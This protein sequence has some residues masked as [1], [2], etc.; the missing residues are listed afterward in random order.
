MNK[1]IKEI[2]ED[3][4]EPLTND[5]DAN[6]ELLDIKKEKYKSH[7]RYNNLLDKILIKEKNY[8]DKKNKDAYEEMYDSKFTFKPNE[9]LVTIK[10]K[11]KCLPKD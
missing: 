1:E 8:L 11:T 7:P 3:V 6:L 9:N 5:Y 10:L 2:I 4:F